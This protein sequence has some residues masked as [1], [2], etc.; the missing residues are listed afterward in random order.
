MV[1]AAFVSLFEL[2][3]SG[4]SRHMNS[5][6]QLFASFNYHFGG[7][8]WNY[9]FQLYDYCTFFDF[10]MFH[11]YILICIIWFSFAIAALAFPVGWNWWNG[12]KSGWEED[13]NQALVAATLPCSS[14][15]LGIPVVSGTAWEADVPW[16]SQLDCISLTSIV[17]WSVDI[18]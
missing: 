11:R 12:A 5:L 10:C 13:P 9:F 17:D 1:I 6:Y 18:G 16:S 15:S 2:R 8:S 4:N 14:E 3:N 7:P